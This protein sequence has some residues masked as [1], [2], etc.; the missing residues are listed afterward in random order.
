MGR[1]ALS[2]ALHAERAALAEDLATLDSDQ[3]AQPSLC[4][5]WNVEEVV[6]HLTA[7]A[8]LGP[9]RW[10]ASVGGAGFDFDRH[11]ARRVAQYRGA[12]AGET[13]ER[14]RRVINSNTSAPGPAAAWLGE[15]VVHGEDIRRP[16]GLR[17]TVPVEVLGAIADFYSRTNF[18]L[19]S[20]SVITGLR[21]EATDGPWSTGDGPVV[22]GST[23]ALI[24]VM[25]ERMSHGDDLS[26]PGVPI[27][28][29]R[30]G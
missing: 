6:A 21:L 30:G 23:L 13:L 28:L 26:G 11:N 5:R 7:A 27:L 2:Q 29:A 14:F 25:A 4:G 17:C 12:T 22:R 19:N 1:G 20:R 18:T 8:S 3:W 16:L 10:F 9:L 24:M 15:V